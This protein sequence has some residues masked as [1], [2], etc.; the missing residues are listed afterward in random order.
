MYF[1]GCFFIFGLKNYS[2]VN[3]FCVFKSV[4]CLSYL[5]IFLFWEDKTKERKQKI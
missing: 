2:D 4:L 5:L 1:V 3:Y